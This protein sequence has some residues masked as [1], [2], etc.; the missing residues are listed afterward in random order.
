MIRDQEDRSST[1]RSVLSGGAALFA[2]A[3]FPQPGRAQQPSTVRLVVGYTAGGGVDAAARVLAPGLEPR[4]AATVIV[5]NRPGAGS[6]L[7][8]R[9]VSEAP[10]DGEMALLATSSNIAIAP[11]VY[12]SLPYDPRK[13]LTA[14]G[15]VSVNASVLAVNKALPVTTLKEFAAYCK[16]RPDNISFG[17]SGVGTGPHLQGQ[18]LAQ[19]IGVKAT[20]IPYRGGAQAL[21][22][23]VAGRFDYSIDFLG[24]F[25]PQILSGGVRALAVVADQ[26]IASLPDVPTMAEAGMPQMDAGSWNGLFLPPRTPRPIVE[27]WAAALR[28]AQ[29]D[30]NVIS[31]LNAQGSQ[32]ASMD[33][34]AFSAF[35]AEEIDRWKELARLAGMEPI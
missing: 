26:R 30:A 21:T 18:R 9:V 33:P 35:V 2:A 1:R 25:L 34:D 6:T 4:L 10:P 20:H 28:H 27:R 16:T 13:D 8:A 31:K 32:A 15:L 17:S 29:A 11:A 3:C 22:D 23:L 12:K 19:L 14:V 24:L 5:D 7:G